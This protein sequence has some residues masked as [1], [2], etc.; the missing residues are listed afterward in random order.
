MNKRDL[1]IGLHRDVVTANAALYQGIFESDPD[2]ATD[3]YWKEA[4]S[5]HAELTR[6]QRAV[7]LRIMRQ[8]S[9]DTISNVL[10]LI[11]GSSVMEGYRGTF[12]LHYDGQVLS[13]LQDAFLELEE[14]R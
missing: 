6:D 11:D 2:K 12:I 9:V 5:F 10:G 7:L 3:P 1:A 13:D 8:V 14:S 4:L